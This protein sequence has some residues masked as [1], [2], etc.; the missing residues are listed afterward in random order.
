MVEE[1]KEPGPIKTSIND[2]QSQ[3]SSDAGQGDKEPAEARPKKEAEEGKVQDQRIAVVFN[4]L[5]IQVAEAMTASELEDPNLEDLRHE[6]IHGVC[7]MPL[8]EMAIEGLEL[9][10][11]MKESDISANVIV[12]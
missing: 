3:G 9:D 6:S 4:K 10:M 7:H 2:T 5:Q 8:I 12:Q 1:A 11:T